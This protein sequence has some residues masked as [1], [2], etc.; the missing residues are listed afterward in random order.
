LI[1]ATAPS[2]R[3]EIVPSQD[4]D[5]SHAHLVASVGSPHVHVASQPVGAVV[6]FWAE[7]EQGGLLPAQPPLQ[8]LQSGGKFLMNS[9]PTTTFGMSRTPTT[10]TNADA[11]IRTEAA[12]FI[13]FFTLVM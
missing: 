13:H 1:P 4:A 8:V 9:S 7:V 10:R 5:Y 11:A 2:S 6:H 3:L 12:P